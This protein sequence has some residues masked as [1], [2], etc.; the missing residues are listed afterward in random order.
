MYGISALCSSTIAAAALESTS[1][2]PELSG[3]VARAATA[4]TATA[5]AAITATTTIAVTAA[6][7]LPSI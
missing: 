6:A 5:A 3:E 7:S 2:L 1:T 4:A